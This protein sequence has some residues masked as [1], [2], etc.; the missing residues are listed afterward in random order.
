MSKLENLKDF[1]QEFAE[2][3]K[4]RLQE[5]GEAMTK[6]MTAMVWYTEDF[7]T[8]HKGMFLRESNYFTNFLLISKI[9][10]KAAHCTR[11]LIQI[12]FTASGKFAS[13]PLPPF[14][15]N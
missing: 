8:F 10:K 14:I 1:Y 2:D 15:I 5:H 11:I 3:S 12:E 13:Q 6:V 9:K 7:F 4:L